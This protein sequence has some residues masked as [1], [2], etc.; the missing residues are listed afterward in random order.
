MAGGYREP[1]NMVKVKGPRKVQ[2]I[3]E[4]RRQELAEGS[5]LPSIFF[6]RSL[7][8]FSNKT[9]TAVVFSVLATFFC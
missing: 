2:D 6:E 9:T 3:L 7:N 5:I 4:Q 1:T 8:S